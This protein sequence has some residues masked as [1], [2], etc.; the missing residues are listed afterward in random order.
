MTFGNNILLQ[1]FNLPK[2]VHYVSSDKLNASICIRRIFE[3]EN[4]HWTNANF[5]QLRPITSDMLRF[6]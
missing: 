3:S 2:P 6:D 1:S 5:D 4:S